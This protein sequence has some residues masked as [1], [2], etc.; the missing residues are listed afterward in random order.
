MRNLGR[1]M[2]EFQKGIEEGRVEVARATAKTK[3]LQALP[4]QQEES[5]Q[6]SEISSH[7]A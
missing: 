4:S 7:H 1:S 2:G 5:M 3:E 6:A